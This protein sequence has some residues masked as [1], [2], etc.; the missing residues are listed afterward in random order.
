[1]KKILSSYKGLIVLIITLV[2]V[3]MQTNAQNVLADVIPT[4][5]DVS[6]TGAFTYTVPLRIPPGIKGMVPNLS[7]Y[8][9]SQGSNGM[10]GCGWDVVGFSAI[11]RTGN[12]IF[13]QNKVNPVTF[14]NTDVFVLDGQ[15]LFLLNGSSDSYETEIRNYKTIKSFG[16][17]GNGPDYFTVEDA[18][19]TVYEYGNSVS[20]KMYAEGRNNTNV[21]QWAIN[22]IYDR[23]GN[24]MEFEYYNDPN[25]GEY[26]ITKISYTGNV[27]MG[28][29]PRSEMFFNYITRADRNRTWFLGSLVQDNVILDNIDIVQ[30]GASINKYQFSYQADYSSSFPEIN[31]HLTE[32]KEIR[33]NNTELPVITVNWGERDIHLI[34]LPVVAIPTSNNTIAN[35]PII[36]TG[37]F[38]G[39]GYTDFTTTENTGSINST[40]DLFINNKSGDFNKTTVNQPINSGTIRTVN[41]NTSKMFLDYNGDGHDD[42]IMIVNG[43][44]PLSNSKTYEM[45]CYL[46][47][48]TS[49]Q[50]P[51]KIFD[52]QNNSSNHAADWI[53]N[54]QIQA[55]DFDGDKKTEFLIAIPSVLNSGGPLGWYGREHDYEIVGYNYHTTGPVQC[56][57]NGYLFDGDF[58]YLGSIPFPIWGLQVLDFNGDGNDDIM[59]VDDKSPSPLDCEIYTIDFTYSDDDG[60]PTIV[61]T[62]GSSFKNIYV[63]DFPNHLHTIIKTGD[64]N[65]DGMADL[66]TWVPGANSS[67]PGTWDI[68]YSTGYPQAGTGPHGFYFFGQGLPQPLSTVFT[69][70]EPYTLLK[71]AYIADFNGD[72]KDDILRIDASNAPT[73]PAQY[74]IFYSKGNN[75]F[76]HEG[77]DMPYPFEWNVLSIGDF[78]GDGQ[79]DIMEHHDPAVAYHPNLYFFHPDDIRNVVTSIENA[80]QRLEIENK[81]LTRDNLYEEKNDNY[82]QANVD[83]FRYPLIR[84]LMPIKVVSEIKDNIEIDKKY[85]YSNLVIHALGLGNRGFT[86]IDIEDISGSKWTMNNYINYW[87]DPGTYTPTPPLLL[88]RTP[89]L[90]SSMT[91][92]LAKYNL[93]LATNNISY[94]DPIYYSEY[95]YSHPELWTGKVALIYLTEKREVNTANATDK[96]CFFAYD[97]PS[98]SSKTYLYGIPNSVS[99]LS[100]GINQASYISNVKYFTYDLSSSFPT[101][102]ISI[103]KEKSRTGKPLFSRT[104][105]MS[106]TNEGLIAQEVKDPGTV[107]ETTTNYVYDPVGNLNTKELIA[108]GTPGIIEM[109]SYTPDYRFVQTVQDMVGLINTYDYNEWGEKIAHTTPDG[110]T[111][112]YQ[113]DASNR[114]IKT[115]LPTQVEQIVT[116]DWADNDPDK[117]IDA[118][119]PRFKVTHETVGIQGFDATFYDI[120]G[121]EIRNAYTAFDGQTIYKDVTYNSTGTINSTSLPYFKN[122]F[123]VLTDFKYDDKDREIKRTTQNGPVITTDYLFSTTDNWLETTVTNIN[124]N[125]V[126]KTYTDNSGAVFQVVDN[127]NTIEYDLNSNGQYDNII[128]NGNQNLKTEYQYDGIGR[129]IS[130]KEPN[131]GTTTYVY[132]RLDQLITE[133]DAN[134]NQF[135]F[136]YDML[137]RKATKSGSNS[138]QYTYTYEDNPNLPATGKLLSIVSP[139]NNT[140]FDYEYDNFGRQS[141]THETVNGQTFS[142]FSQYDQ[143]N[144]KV[145]HTYPSQDEIEYLYNNYGFLEQV[146]LAQT[147]LGNPPLQ[148]PQVLWKL[149]QKDAMD[150]VTDAD[151]FSAAPGNAPLYKVMRAYDVLGY[152]DEDKL[153]NLNTNTDIADVDYNFDG[154]GGY[155]SHRVDM[156]R[157]MQEYFNYDNYLRLTKV[158]HTIPS[159]PSYPDLEIEYDA[160]GDNIGNISKKSDASNPTTAQNYKWK[161]E[162]SGSTAN[163]FAV[164]QVPLPGSSVPMANSIPLV[165]QD[166]EWTTFK[167][168]KKITEYPNDLEFTYGP[169]EMRSM[170]VYSSLGAP[171]KTRYY[172]SNFEKT[173]MAA[174]GVETSS[175]YVFAEGEL[176]AIITHVTDQPSEIHYT[177]TDYQG[178]ITHILDNTGMGGNNGNGLLEERSFNAWGRPRNPDTWQYYATAPGWMYDRGYTGHEHLFDFGII[179]MNGRLYDPV[180]GRM[181]SPDPVLADVTNSQ[182]YNKYSYVF[183]NPLKYTDP[184]G[185]NPLVL[186]G[187]AGGF[188]G[189]AIN[190]VVHADDI[191]KGGQINWAKFGAAAGIGFAAGFV[192]GFTGGLA[193]LEAAGTTTSI[194]SAFIGYGAASATSTSLGST[195]QSTG[196]AMVFGDPYPTMGEQLTEFGINFVTA[197]TI[198][199]IQAKMNGLPWADKAVSKSEFRTYYS[200]LTGEEAAKANPIKLNEVSVSASKDG[201]KAT[202][203]VYEGVDAS[204]KVK[205]VGITGR[206]AAARFG[207]HLNSGTSRSLLD[208]RVIDGATGLSK[209]QARIWEQT[210]INQYGLGKN[211]GQLPNKVNSIAPKYWWQYGIK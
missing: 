182:A 43:N 92:D 40:F 152:P 112:N 58:Q 191:V 171:V 111:I 177:F 5:Y 209:T 163:P 64:F 146:Q 11:K 24:Y 115:I 165:Q 31:T 37:D 145:S 135:D 148:A 176:I 201:S 154:P 104:T 39:D 109:Y 143:Y 41:A 49:F 52:Y 166:V 162:T 32:I 102:P 206:D 95:F 15:R 141:A 16:A 34:N 142:S 86:Q 29:M 89:V 193:T 207:E 168:V 14:T 139:Y 33:P 70:N 53:A 97:A 88:Y 66:L 3:S 198:A 50:P 150:K 98:P 35:K 87:V 55:G 72:G 46:S 138:L 192:T 167:R 170:A 42:M 91:F 136:T 159:N 184:D 108:I 79:A 4:S 153:T 62:S 71:D 17:S 7:I 132:N 28:L 77:G 181:F 128:I 134:G 13:H 186:A 80:G 99:E 61:Y 172:A 56:G 57:P 149:N 179:N 118:Y 22:K 205:Y 124:T 12:T 151:Y 175:S 83:H 110:L 54:M 2:H 140:Q 106:Y 133:I 30:N 81:P 161:Y 74:D 202:Y 196:N 197:G 204:G 188:I 189:A 38:N 105:D 51:I 203:S 73:G 107:Y 129:T 180:L 123:P 157:G 147:V 178:S 36:S 93:W 194:T 144:R 120:Y 158:R 45:Y 78:N 183:N 68:A 19:G 6:S 200:S 130:K 173:V 60:I 199:G 47:N 208:Y 103:R 1:M 8:Y 59:I 100:Y 174:T 169:D 18:D 26:R 211:S 23:F 122:N 90:S 63:G 126:K 155:L 76:V 185:N 117:P 67:V 48:G 9:N 137:G 195:I 27:A 121:R 94:F 84:R 25:D 82:G 101:K 96:D 190:I 21:L 116:Y 85:H 75:E 187:L 156:L 131:A 119:H 210:L 44:V 125:E 113:Y 20:S 10:L 160:S 164:T 65:G 127:D 69:G 114:L